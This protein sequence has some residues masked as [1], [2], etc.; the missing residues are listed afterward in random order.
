MA[1]VTELNREPDIS[2]KTIDAAEVDLTDV[3]GNAVYPTIGDVPAEYEEE[4]NMVYTESDG[5]VVFE[6]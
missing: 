1:N 5:L 6:S 3:F 2:A 4:G